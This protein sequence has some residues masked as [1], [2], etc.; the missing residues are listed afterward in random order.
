[1]KNTL[2][3]THVLTHISVS[4]VAA[5]HLRGDPVLSDDVVREVVPGN[6]RKAE[7]FVGL[8]RR[9]TEY[10]KVWESTRASIYIHDYHLI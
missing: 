1:M 2:I 7:H 3:K 10:L 8:M 4:R 6:I 5:D 9:F